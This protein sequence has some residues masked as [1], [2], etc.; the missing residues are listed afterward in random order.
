MNAATYH[1]LTSY[2]RK[3]MSPHN[4]D[5]GHMPRLYKSYPPLFS[6]ALQ[7]AGELPDVSLM[8]AFGEK[9]ADRAS[10]AVLNFEGLSTILTLANG[11]TAKRSYGTQTHF[12]RSAPSAGALYPNEI[13]VATGPVDGLAPGIYNYQVKSAALTQLRKGR[14]RRQVA[15]A[16]TDRPERIPA[17]SLLISGIFFR[18]AWK[19]RQRAYRYVLLD[20]GHLIENLTLALGSC[21]YSYSVHYDFDDESMGHLLGIDEEREACLACMNIFDNRAAVVRQPEE[22]SAALAGLERSVVEASRVSAAEVSYTLITQAYEAGKTVQKKRPA[23]KASYPVVDNMPRDW[24]PVRQAVE[25]I[26]S[27]DYVKSVLTRRSIR[28]FIAYPLPVDG[29]LKLLEFICL[30]AGRNVDEGE[31]YAG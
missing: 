8:K 28:N 19:Y 25:P 9:W 23:G 26:V 7:P 2:H 17:A 31:A 22:P 12:Y 4:L 5:W 14:Y 30:A 15:E 10:P 29:I 20:A 24:F 13:Y 6:T 21:G 18:S 16:L 3:N 11:F 1:K 27:P